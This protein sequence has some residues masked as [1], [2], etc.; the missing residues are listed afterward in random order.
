M[1]LLLES[2]A[3]RN[4]PLGMA[5]SV[6]IHA[7]LVG[8]VV[9]AY[10]QEQPDRQRLLDEFVTFLVPPDRPREQQRVEGASFSGT[11][12]A[13]NTRGTEQGDGGRAVELG[14]GPVDEESG[15][16]A[17]SVTLSIDLPALLGDSVHM[18]IDVDS[19]V[20]RYPWSAAPDYPIAMLQQNIEGHAFV[21]YIVDTLGT[22]DSASV[23]VVR[24]SHDEFVNAVKR[25]MPKMRFRPAI[26][27]GK[28]VQQ[29]VQQNF[30]FRIQRPD[31][32]L[33]PRRGPPQ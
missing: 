27:G 3:N 1:H 20:Q 17:Q 12:A 10:R 9:V 13:E 26:L 28:K 30:S 29:L 24:A 21:I 16:T 18:E 14:T 23:R 33:T 22:A 19:A 5:A 8:A 6:V 4:T 15:D 11:A 31:S 7:L 32:V 25:A 2:H